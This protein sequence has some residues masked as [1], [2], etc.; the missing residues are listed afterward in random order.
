MMHASVMVGV[1]SGRMVSDRM[2]DGTGDG[3]MFGGDCVLVGGHS[4]RRWNDPEIER[5]EH[6]QVVSSLPHGQAPG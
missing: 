2:M 3:G 1:H 6:R 4:H 5:F